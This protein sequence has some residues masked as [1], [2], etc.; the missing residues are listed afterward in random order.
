M[1]NKPTFGLLTRAAA[2]AESTH[3]KRSD[4]TPSGLAAT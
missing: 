3:A 2:P 4:T 1:A